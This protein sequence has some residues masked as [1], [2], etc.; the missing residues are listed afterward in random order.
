MQSTRDGI[1]CKDPLINTGVILYPQEAGEEAHEVGEEAHQGT[2][3]DSSTISWGL[4][5]N[6]SSRMHWMC[7]PV[8]FPNFLS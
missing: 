2:R 3:T 6:A 1:W 5:N 7:P 8:S 4:Y